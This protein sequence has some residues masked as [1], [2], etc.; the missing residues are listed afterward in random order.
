MEKDMSLAG[1]NIGPGPANINLRN[2]P[3][4]QKPSSNKTTIAQ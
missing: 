3:T 4:S 2:V 1:A